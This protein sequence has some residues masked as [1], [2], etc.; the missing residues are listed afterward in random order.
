M[1]SGIGSWRW[2]ENGGRFVGS[3]LHKELRGPISR[4]PTIEEVAAAESCGFVSATPSSAGKPV[5]TVHALTPPRA[6]GGRAIT[7]RLRRDEATFRRGAS[8]TFAI[9]DSVWKH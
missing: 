8:C 7:F 9:A 3:R 5:L 1:L 4:Q 6:G 2:H